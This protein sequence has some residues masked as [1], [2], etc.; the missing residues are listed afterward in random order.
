M[1]WTP[2]AWTRDL[3]HAVRMLRRTPGFLAVSVATLGLAIGVTAGMFAVVNVVLLDPL[4]YAHP[5]RLVYIGASAPG[6]EIPGEFGVSA[7]FFI[8]YSEQSK[9]LEDAGTF[10]NFTA[11][12]R[13]D[14]R[15]E[16]IWMSSSTP[17]L[18]TTLGAR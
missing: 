15:A 18:F 5:D 2:T 14:E 16:R 12:F 10:N 7:E 3:K 8:Q 13:I 11:T 1:Q 17:S 9:L 4:P 6:S